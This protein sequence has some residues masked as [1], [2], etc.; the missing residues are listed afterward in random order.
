MAGDLRCSRNAIGFGQKAE[1]WSIG[2]LNRAEAERWWHRDEQGAD[3]G[4]GQR[5]YF[6][7]DARSIGWTHHTGPIAEYV[8][9][10]DRRGARDAQEAPAQRHQLMVERQAGHVRPDAEQCRFV[11]G[12]C[13][14]LGWRRQ[15]CACRADAVDWRAVHV[16]RQRSQPAFRP[17]RPDQRHADWHAVAVKSCRNLDSGQITQ[18]DEVG[19]HAE[20]AVHGNRIGSHVGQGR[21][22]RN[23][24]QQQCVK[25]A[26]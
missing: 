13:V 7:F 19:E 18:V 3:R 11:S 5:P 21:A 15:W 22:E 24:R 16:I 26:K 6:A 25:S 12:Q 23:C 10:V 17:G 4:G 14:R 20:P 1:V 9:S 8:Q 2:Q